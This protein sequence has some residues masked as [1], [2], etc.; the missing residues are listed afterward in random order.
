MHYQIEDA[1]VF[2]RLDLLH[3]FKECEFISKIELMSYFNDRIL[4][5]D[6]SIGCFG[7][8]EIKLRSS[9]SRCQNTLKNSFIKYYRLRCYVCA[10]IVDI[11]IHF[12]L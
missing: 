5:C 3:I 9:L 8:D 2:N 4:N 10:L 6:N 12:A 7:S 1:V 11:G